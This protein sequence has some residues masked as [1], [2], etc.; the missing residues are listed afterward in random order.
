V[1]TAVGTMLCVSTAFKVVLHPNN[2]FIMEE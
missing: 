1:N 2:Q